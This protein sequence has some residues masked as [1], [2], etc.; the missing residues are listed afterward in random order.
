MKTFFCILALIVCTSVAIAADNNQT[1]VDNDSYTNSSKEGWWWG[2][3]VA[4]EE[5]KEEKRDDDKKQQVTVT[6][7][8]LQQSWPTLEELKNMPP[9]EMGKVLGEARDL[10]VQYPTEGNVTRY[11]DYQD[12][13]RRKG[14]AFMNTSMYVWQ[15]HPELSTSTDYPLTTP[16]R[17]AMTRDTKEEVELSIRAAQNDFALLYFYAPGCKY[18]EAQEGILKFFTTKYGWQI[19]PEEIS[20]NQKLAARL[21]VD[22]TPSLVLIKNGSDDF[23]PVSSGVV[24]VPELEDNLFR[25]IR[26]MSGEITPEEY[27]VYDREKGGPFDV[28]A[29][30]KINS[31]VANGQ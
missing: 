28:N 11:Y 14:L 5:K 25:G 6:V 18:C 12:V 24:A 1:P 30:L 17:N 21:G 23:I 26:F 29:P 27:S 13:Y 19:Q 7:A 4:P 16:G 8:P 9:K 15:K 20:A 10:A 22:R 31:G 3:Y 2:K